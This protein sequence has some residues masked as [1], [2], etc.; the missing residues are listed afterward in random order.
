M[1]VDLI[2]YSLPYFNEGPDREL[3][4]RAADADAI[5]CVVRELLRLKREHPNTIVHS[6]MGI[7]SIPDWLLKGPQMKVPCDKY[8]LIWVGADGTVQLCYVTFKLG[9]LYERRLSEMLYGAKHCRAARDCFALKCPNCH[10]GYDSRVQKHFESRALYRDD[11]ILEAAGSNTPWATVA[12]GMPSLPEDIVQIS[13]S[14]PIG[15]GRSPA[16]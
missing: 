8:Q 10:C 3:Q 1:Q 16:D 13:S 15:T 4:F 2:H 9:N 6:E 14:T 5:R 11:S 12:A 7:R